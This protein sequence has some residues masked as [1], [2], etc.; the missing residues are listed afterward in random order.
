MRN[1]SV[2][3]KELLKIYIL[4]GIFFSGHRVGGPGYEERPPGPGRANGGVLAMVNIGP[5][6]PRVQ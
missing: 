2:F 3:S 4:T 6:G 1:Y 5:G